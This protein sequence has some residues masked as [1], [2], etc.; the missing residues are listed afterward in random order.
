MSER[1]FLRMICKCDKRLLA[2]KKSLNDDSYNEQA[3]DWAK[4]MILRLE[5]IREFLI[6]R[7]EL[8]KTPSKNF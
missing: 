8:S 6:V 3:K 1:G 7:Y 2:F 4:I 5:A